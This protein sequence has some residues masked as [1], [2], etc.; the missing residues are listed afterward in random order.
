MFLLYEQ[1]QEKTLQQVLRSWSIMT[2][3]NS[4]NAPW[5]RDPSLR[6]IYWREEHHYSK[7]YALI[8]C[9]DEGDGEFCLVLRWVVV[10]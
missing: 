6:N 7:R 10:W 3:Q 8:W 1:T 4:F 5:H 2:I 9:Y